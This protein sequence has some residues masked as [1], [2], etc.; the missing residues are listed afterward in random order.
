MKI[1]QANNQW[2]IE[3]ELGSDP[4]ESAFALALTAGIKGVAM[5]MDQEA[6]PLTSDPTRGKVIISNHVL[7]FSSSVSVC[8]E[9]LAAIAFAFVSF[10]IRICC[11]CSFPWFCFFVSLF[12]F[13]VCLLLCCSASLFFVFQLFFPNA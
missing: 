6:Q 13:F 10:P 11:F 5:V 7:F 2:T 12:C 1:A 9:C 3:A 4:M 8:S